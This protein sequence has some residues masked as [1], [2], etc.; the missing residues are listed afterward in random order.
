[1]GFALLATTARGICS[2]RL[3]ESA[4]PSTGLE[5]LRHDFP[6]ATLTAD[7]SVARS[8]TG[9]SPTSWRVNRA[10]AC[11]STSTA[12]P[13]RSGSGKR[14]GPSPAARRGP[15]AKS[16]GPSAFRQAP[17]AVGAA[18][19]ANPVWLLVPCHRVVRSGG[20][21]GGYYWGLDMKQA[22]LDLE[23]GN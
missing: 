3:L 22:L 21:L 23:S 15:T 14:S 13:S 5:R 10:T 8:L 6:N 2:F 20:G 11:R 4:D 9:C 12:R 18:C 17:R 16:R 7:A 19:G 1:M